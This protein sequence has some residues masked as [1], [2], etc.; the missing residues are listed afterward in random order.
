MVVW[1]STFAPTKLKFTNISY[2]HIYIM[3]GN[4]LPNHQIYFIFAMAICGPTIKFNFRQYF[5]LYGIGRLQTCCSICACT[6]THTHTYIVHTHVLAHTHIHI[7]ILHT[8]TT[9]WLMARPINH[10]SSHNTIIII[11]KI[12]TIL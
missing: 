3:Y 2:L 11:I 6:H 7:L 5:R 1:R 10:Y 9:Y 4:P 8:H 12:Y